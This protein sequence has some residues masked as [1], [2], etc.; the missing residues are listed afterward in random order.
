MTYPG[1][2]GGGGESAGFVRDERKE[3]RGG[4]SAGE[5][6][7]QACDAVFPRQRPGTVS[8]RTVRRTWRHGPSRGWQ[9][10]VRRLVLNS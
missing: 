1:I 6:A 7:G 3:E 8:A 4:G 9:S 10:S 2:G 5:P